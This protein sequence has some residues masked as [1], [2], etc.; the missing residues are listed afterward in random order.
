M[1]EQCWSCLSNSG[2]R[3]ISP[4]PP[5]HIGTYWLVEHAYPSSL[6]GWLVIVLKRHAEALHDLTSEEFSE[7]A[8]VLERTVRTLNELLGPAK[9]YVACYA[10]LE[11]FRHV[12]FHVVPRAAEISPDRLGTKSFG[13]LKVSEAEAPGDEIRRFCEDAAA[14]F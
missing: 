1:T 11:N 5:I 14:I 4:G 10:E 6:A 9:E 7:F 3:R 13:Y 8:G 2:E 12:H